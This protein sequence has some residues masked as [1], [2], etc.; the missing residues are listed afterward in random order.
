MRIRRNLAVSAVAALFATVG[1]LSALPAFATTTVV[2]NW[3][4]LVT[5]VDAIGAGTAG[6]IQLGSDITSSSSPQD[7][8][9]LHD[10]LVSGGAIV[11]LDLAGHELQIDTANASADAAITVPES[12][13]LIIDDTVGGGVLGASSAGGAGIGGG[14][15]H[16]VVGTIIIESGEVN[17]NSGVVNAAGLGSG[18]NGYIA[19]GITINGGTVTAEN[20]GAGAGI[21]TGTDTS[22]P[23]FSCFPSGNVTITGGTVSAYGWNGGSGGGGAGIGSGPGACG[24]NVVIT[25]G[26]ITA[27]GNNG[28]AGIG[29]GY[30]APDALTMSVSI[31]GGTILA[32]GDRGGAG[33]G[34]G[35]GDGNTQN[36]IPLVSISG[37]AQITAGGGTDSVYGGGAGIGSGSLF[38]GNPTFPTISMDGSAEAGSA[39]SGGSG[40]DGTMEVGGPGYLM[41]FSGSSS[42]TFSVE[43]LS[44]PTPGYGGGVQIV[45]TSIVPPTPTPDNSG[46]TVLASTGANGSAISALAAVLG[47]IGFSLVALRRRTRRS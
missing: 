6:T 17:V 30:N 1:G 8:L 45:C 13:T 7:Y 3:A 2:T 36:Q 9:L 35:Q 21:G 27:D 20:D 15:T 10:N 23:P 38:Y 41:D 18:P 22:Q 40:T 5:A 37:C 47:L 19:G 34:S 32:I 24:P 12:S 4:D 28:G 16:S 31:A 42:T 25:G 26:T 39:D 43:T 29:T 11:T 14:V 46:T 33:I 44:D